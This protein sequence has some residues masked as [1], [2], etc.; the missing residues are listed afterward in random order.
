MGLIWA[1]GGVSFAIMWAG[2]GISQ[3]I[4]RLA[5]EIRGKR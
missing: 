1:I 3:A 5:N 4:D 2:Y